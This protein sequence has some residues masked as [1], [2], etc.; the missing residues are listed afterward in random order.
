MLCT[1]ASRPESRPRQQSPRW[2]AADGSDIRSDTSS[3]ETSRTATLDS[4]LPGFA[5]ILAANELSEMQQLNAA[6]ELELPVL[7]PWD[8]KRLDAG[9]VE[10]AKKS[11]GNGKA[12]RQPGGK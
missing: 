11:V 1:Q 10:Y 9:T 2:L 8:R 7:G 3:L 4:R 6:D 5:G 12:G